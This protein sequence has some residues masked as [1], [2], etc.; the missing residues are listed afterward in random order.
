MASPE[1]PA[2]R[3][4]LQRRFP[5]AYHD[6]D[7]LRHLN[8]AAYLP[9]M[10]TLRCGYYLDVIGREDPA[11]LDII[12][13]EACCRYL[14]PVRYGVELVGEVAPVRPL[15]RTSFTLAYRFTDASDG[16]TT[17][18]GRTVLVTYDYARGAKREIP[19]ERRRRL[20]ADALDPEQTGWE[21]VPRRST[22][23]G[24]A[25]VDDRHGRRR[26]GRP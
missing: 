8:H 6:L 24:G 23:N 20:E 19:P 14:V 21:P 22:R 25:G 7:V 18:L 16:A 11:E 5:V 1:P 2:P 3:W 17:A 9:M 13:A 12:V 4:P 26:S 15:G 10:E